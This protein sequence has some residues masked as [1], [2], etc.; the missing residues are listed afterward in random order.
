MESIFDNEK[1]EWIILLQITHNW[2]GKIGPKKELTYRTIAKKIIVS[3][4]T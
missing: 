1:K 3:K 4:K 2:F